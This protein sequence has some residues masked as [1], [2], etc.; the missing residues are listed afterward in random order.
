MRVFVTGTG[1]CGTT[2]FSMAC[3]HFSG[4]TSK[5]ESTNGRLSTLDF[6]DN[7]IESEP[8]LVWRLP[9]LIEKYPDAIYVHLLRDKDLCVKSLSKR[10]SLDHYAKFTERVGRNNYS[11]SVLANNYYDFVV[12]TVELYFKTYPI[13]TITM[14]L[15]P[16]FDVWKDFCKELSVV[17]DEIKKSYAEW[18]IKYNK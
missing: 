4:D 9:Q 5:H 17:S 11:R 16:S 1:R 10:S 7:H 3:K 12:G 14:P 8:G 13:N 6:P 18:E 2:T 15:I